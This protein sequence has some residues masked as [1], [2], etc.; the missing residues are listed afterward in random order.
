METALVILPI[1]GVL[2]IGIISPGPS[3]ILVARTAVAN[4]RIAAFASALGM[5]AGAFVL[6]SAAL[7]GLHVIFQQ[8]PGAYLFLKILGGLYLIYLAVRTWRAADSEI[9]V[10]SRN[11]SDDANV[12]RHFFA[13]ILT[14]LTNPKAALQYGVIFSAMLPHEITPAI[15]LSLPVCVFALEL[16]WYAIV[17]YALSAPRTRD[18]YLRTKCVADRIAGALLGALGA[19]LLVASR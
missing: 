19:K 10:S 9:L 15:A 11:D 8:I 18:A 7:L 13:A 16:S 6:A 1:L 12:A 4:S 5:A 17:A 3:F 2:V 14:M